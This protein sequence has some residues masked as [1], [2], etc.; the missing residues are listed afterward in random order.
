VMEF[1]YAK[2]HELLLKGKSEPVIAWEI[3]QDSPFRAR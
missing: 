1:P 3:T 2:R